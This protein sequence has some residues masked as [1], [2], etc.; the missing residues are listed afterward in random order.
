MGN[1]SNHS[2][3]VLICGLVFQAMHDFIQIER[4]K[5]I[6]TFILIL[7]GI[8]S[9]AQQRVDKESRIPREPQAPHIDGS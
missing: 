8:K 6:I 1:L 4:S 2:T 5:G 7:L 3:T 9:Y